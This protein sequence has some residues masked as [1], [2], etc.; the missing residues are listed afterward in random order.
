MSKK[1]TAKPPDP[2][3]LVKRLVDVKLSELHNWEFWGWGHDGGEDTSDYWQPLIA[4]LRSEAQAS[5]EGG[6][7]EWGAWSDKDDNE[8]YARAGFLVGIE[9][10]R[11]LGGAR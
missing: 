7:G 11:R 4:G 9:L 1:K 5:L 6:P 8:V 10:G 2:R 3:E